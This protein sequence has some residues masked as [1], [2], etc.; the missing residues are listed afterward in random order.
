MKQNDRRLWFYYDKTTT[1][2]QQHLHIKQDIEAGVCNWKHFLKHCPVVLT[3]DIKK[4][5]EICKMTH[6]HDIRKS[7]TL[8]MS[9]SFKHPFFF[10]IHWSIILLMIKCFQILINQVGSNTHSVMLVHVRKTSYICMTGHS[11]PAE[12]KAEGFHKFNQ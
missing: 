9:T 4:L 12:P 7:R 2:K 8:L 11:F 10:L 3:N 6:W 1:K 5:F